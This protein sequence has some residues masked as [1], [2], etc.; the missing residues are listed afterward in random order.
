MAIGDSG[1]NVESSV[2]CHGPQDNSARVGKHDSDN[3]G[4]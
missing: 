4:M 3:D 2:P 1:K